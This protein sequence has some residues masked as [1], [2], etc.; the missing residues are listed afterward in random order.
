MCNYVRCHNVMMMSVWEE[1]S[2][3]NDDCDVCVREMSNCGNDEDENDVKLCERRF[4]DTFSSKYL[5]LC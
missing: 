3:Y 4:C 1:V 5:I 2:K